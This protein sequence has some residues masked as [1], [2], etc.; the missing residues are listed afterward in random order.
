MIVPPPFLLMPDLWVPGV[1]LSNEHIACQKWRQRTM[2]SLL[3][4]GV[5]G[6]YLEIMT[7]NVIDR[8]TPSGP[9]EGPVGRPPMATGNSQP[10]A[11]VNPDWWHGRRDDISQENGSIAG[12]ET[13]EAWQTN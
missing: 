8:S 2:M 13:A 9:S 7:G 4:K 10:V 1:R 3:D 11:R 5:R 6:G 12:D